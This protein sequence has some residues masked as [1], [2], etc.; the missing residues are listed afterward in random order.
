METP[1]FIEL[2]RNNTLFYFIVSNGVFPENLSEYNNINFWSSSSFDIEHTT[3]GDEYFTWVNVM[4]DK[5]F[6]FLAFTTDNLD[7][8]DKPKYYFGRDGITKIKRGYQIN[9]EIIKQ[10][11][12]DLGVFHIPELKYPIH[13]EVKKRNDQCVIELKILS[14]EW[15]EKN[16]A[17]L[18]YYFNGILTSSAVL[19]LL[20]LEE[21]ILKVSFSPDSYS[22]QND[23]HFF[24]ID[25]EIYTKD[26][27]ASKEIDLEQ[28]Y[29]LTGFLYGKAAVEELGELEYYQG[30]R[31]YVR[32]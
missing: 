5:S 10:R 1:K 27:I 16:F 30:V 24:K 4:D 3:I 22:I 29:E 20:N 26:E 12:I 23:I 28:D 7:Y 19:G 13:I 2:I 6:V 17:K 9:D 21:F 18:E 31:V 14:R 11:D 25:D 15:K 32:K 8:F